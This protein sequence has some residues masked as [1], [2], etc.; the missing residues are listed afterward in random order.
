MLTKMRTV[1]GCL[2]GAAII[3]I[4]V[5]IIVDV[6]RTPASTAA[7]GKGTCSLVRRIILPDTCV[8]SAAG[9]TCSW[10]TTRPYSIFFTQ[11]ASCPTL[12]CDIN[13]P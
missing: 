7:P 5:L 13:V 2:I 8:C 1:S 11:A 4:V 6:A 10:V 12:G 9:A 3:V